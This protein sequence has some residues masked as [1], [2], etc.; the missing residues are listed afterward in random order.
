[1][2]LIT[3]GRYVVVASQVT[4]VSDVFRCSKSSNYKFDIG[5]TCGCLL[6]IEDEKRGKVTTMREEFLTTLAA[7]P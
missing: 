4:F 6:S 1:M 5:T 7:T 2:T 3:V